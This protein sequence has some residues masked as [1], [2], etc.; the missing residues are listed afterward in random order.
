MPLFCRE[1]IQGGHI[2]QPVSQL[3]EHHPQVLSHSHQHLSQVLHL[4]LAG[5]HP[6]SRPRKLAQLSGAID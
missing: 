1:R 4:Q 2:M 5:F 6:S 3:D